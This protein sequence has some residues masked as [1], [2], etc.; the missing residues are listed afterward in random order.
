MRVM[1]QVRSCDDC[2]L[3]SE[4]CYCKHPMRPQGESSIFYACGETATDTEAELHP[5]WGSPLRRG[6]LLFLLKGAACG[7]H[8]ED[9]SGRAF[10]F[11]S[12]APMPERSAFTDNCKFIRHYCA[13]HWAERG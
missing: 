13:K 9:V 10:S 5:V 6:F 1:H 7:C 11:A 2:P 3:C 12:A 8:D 4:S